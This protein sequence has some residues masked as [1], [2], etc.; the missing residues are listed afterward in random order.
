MSRVIGLAILSALLQPILSLEAPSGGGLN[1]Q[2]TSRAD[3]LRPSRVTYLIGGGFAEN[4]PFGGGGAGSIGYAATAAVEVRAPLSVFRLRGEGL[5]AS[6]GNDQRVSAVTAS[7]LA[8]APVRWR[9]APYLLAGAGGYAAS[10]SG[11]SLER[12]WTLGAGVRI[13][14]GRQGVLVESRIHALLVSESSL[15]R[16]GVSTLDV[17]NTP[18]QYTFTPLTFAIQF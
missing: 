1:A 12:G 7:V 15:Q 18:W 3:S 11:G 17:H 5:F 16:A 2:V 4:P 10:R 8:Q 9:A 6:W 13:P 14:V